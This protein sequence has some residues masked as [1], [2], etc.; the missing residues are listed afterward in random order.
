MNNNGLKLNMFSAPLEVQYVR[1][2]PVACYRGC[3]LRFELLGCE[4]NGECGGCGQ[5]GGG[6]PS[7]SAPSL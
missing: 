6:Q 4:L 3:T 2:Y 5:L 1:L 7:V